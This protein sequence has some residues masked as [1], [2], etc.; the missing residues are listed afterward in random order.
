MIAHVSYLK[1]GFAHQLPLPTGSLIAPC[2]F[3]LCRLR[4]S[5]Y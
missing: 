5:E 3:D 2:V 4:R 1:R